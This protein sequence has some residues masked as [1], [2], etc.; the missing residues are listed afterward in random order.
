M[1]VEKAPEVRPVSNDR[2]RQIEE[3][4]RAI[5]Y[6]T[7]SMYEALLERKGTQFYKDSLG[8]VQ[9]GTPGPHDLMRAASIESLDGIRLSKTLD[10]IEPSGLDYYISLF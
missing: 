5:D 6:Q 8:L 10:M 1:L 3:E 9:V 7:S 2:Q 4:R